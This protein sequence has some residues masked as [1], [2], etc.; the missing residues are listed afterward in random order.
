MV[1]IPIL[2]YI[3]TCEHLEILGHI[4]LAQHHNLNVFASPQLNF[5]VNSMFSIINSSTL[6]PLPCSWPVERM[7]WARQITVSSARQHSSSLWPLPTITSPC[8]FYLCLIFS[9]SQSSLISHLISFVFLFSF[10]LSFSFCS[11]S[12]SSSA[13]CLLAPLFGRDIEAARSSLKERHR[14]E[15]QSAEHVQLVKAKW[16]ERGEKT[17]TH[18]HV[19]LHHREHKYIIKYIDSL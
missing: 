9:L 2:L 14:Q 11:S 17:L 12:S 13:R 7:R 10:V 5:V 4:M 19:S 6:I 15:H 3:V 1:S 18:T 8:S 16:S